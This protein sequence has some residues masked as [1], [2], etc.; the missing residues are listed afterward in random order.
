MTGPGQ[1]P[2]AQP[3][4]RREFAAWKASS[5]GDTLSSAADMETFAQALIGDR[6]LKP[7]TKAAVFVV[8]AQPW[9]VGQAGGAPGSNVIFWVYPDLKA[10]LLVLSNFD[11]PA[12]EQMGS[13][14]GPVLAGGTCQPQAPHALALPPPPA[15]PSS[16]SRPGSAAG[17]PV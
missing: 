15:S 4:P 17:Q 12:G 11:P 1:P 2:A 5:A 6:L 14:L 3:Q 8:R 10:W 7:A 9:R 13:V 16:S